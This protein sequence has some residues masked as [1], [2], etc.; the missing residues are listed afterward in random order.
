M[1][2]YAKVLANIPEATAATMT[3]VDRYGFDLAVTTPTGPRATRLAF[4]EPVT[5]N[6]EVR[7]AMIALVK[8]ARG[9]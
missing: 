2:A 3:S 9:A 6:D 5:T 7:R 1:L 4:D 8:R